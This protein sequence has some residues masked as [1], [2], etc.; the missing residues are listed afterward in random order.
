ME[1]TPVENPVIEGDNFTFICNNTD[2]NGSPALQVNGAVSGDLFDRVTNPPSGVVRE[3]TFPNV[4]KD[5]NGTEFSC[6]IGG[7]S[8]VSVTL[9][10]NCKICSFPVP[11]PSPSPSSPSGAGELV[12]QCAL[13]FRII[14]II[15][16]LYFLHR[17]CWCLCC[18]DYITPSVEYFV[19]VESV[20]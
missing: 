5:D 11:Y 18:G 7:L 15:Y 6:T 8:K 4:T 1:I 13:P 14:Y 2:K 3:F 10:V 19:N 9:I 12:N 17:C 16:I 20:T